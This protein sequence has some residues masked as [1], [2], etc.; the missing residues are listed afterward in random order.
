MYVCIQLRARFVCGHARAQK[1]TRR[2][3]EPAVWKRVNGR[4]AAAAAAFQCGVTTVIV[5]LALDFV[6]RMSRL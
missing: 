1:H 4:V 5:L 2:G 3:Y 6:R